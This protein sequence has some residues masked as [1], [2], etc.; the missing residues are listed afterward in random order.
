MSKILIICA[1]PN[2]RKSRLNRAL[3][4]I[5]STLRDVEVHDLYQHYP[6]FDIDINAEQTRLTNASA[7]IFL[8]PIY[9]YSCPALMKEWIDTVLQQGFA[10]GRNGTKL[11]GKHWLSVISTGGDKD[12]YCDS[13]THHYGVTEFMIPFERTAHLCGMHY[14]PPLVCHNADKIS[15]KD[16]STH[17]D[18][19]AE[20]MS[21]LLTGITQEK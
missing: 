2:L 11:A 20:M 3:V 4:Q 5:A 14:L 6:H 10:F 9:W 7:V 13:G 19:F 8:H 18:I 21:E 12:A 16:I 1:H 15:D 17:C